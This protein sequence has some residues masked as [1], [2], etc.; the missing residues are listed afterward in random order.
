MIRLSRAHVAALFVP[1]AMPAVFVAM[2]AAMVERLDTR[3]MWS[4]G[5]G[6]RE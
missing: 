6:G 3:I 5:M 1:Q 4:I 2:V